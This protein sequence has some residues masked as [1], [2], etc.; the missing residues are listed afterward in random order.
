MAKAAVKKVRVTAKHVAEHR[1][2]SKRDLSPKW[3]GCETWSADQFMKHFRESMQY[4]NLNH[5]G[6]DLKP[7]VINWMGR[8]G[9]TKEQIKSFKDTKDWR[10]S[11]TMGAIASCLNRGMMPVRAD[12]N[13]GKSTALWLG[14][15]IKEVIFDGEKDIVEAE[16]EEK[17]TAPVINIQERLRDAAAK[18]TEEIEDA[19]EKFQTDPDNFDPKEFKMISVLKGKGAKAAHARIIKGFYERDLAELEELASGKGCEQLRE[20]YSHRT[21]K[22]VRKLI[23]FYTEVMSAC[24]MLAEEAKVTRKPRKAKAVNKDKIVSKLKYKKNDDSLK[25]VSVNPVDILGAKELWTYNTKTRK[26]G[27]YV[28]EDFQDLSVKGTSITNF[29]V[30]KSVQKTLRK[31]TEQLKAFKDAGKV[32]LRKFLEDI[33]AVDTKMNGRINTDI[34][35]LKVM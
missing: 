1:A 4:Y 35:L 33:N 7:Q 16:I 21:K 24:N 15:R 17:T 18:M 28:A 32:A 31:P 27:K 10:S 8:N 20:G 5:N 22:Q 6:K 3:D 9:Y 11:V 19:I 25:L 13:N 2:S 30:S 34:I 23:D 14:E 26:L 29:S 12:F